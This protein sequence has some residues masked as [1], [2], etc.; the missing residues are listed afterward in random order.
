LYENYETRQAE[1]VST[2]RLYKCDSG[3]WNKF[4]AIR[5]TVL[6]E[7]K[8]KRSLNNDLDL[9]SCEPHRALQ[10]GGRRFDPCHVHHNSIQYLCGFFKI[11]QAKEFR[12]ERKFGT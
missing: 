6:V 5:A 12:D 4:G 10:A 3:V 9:I 8:A 1:S 11:W 7:R 2:Q